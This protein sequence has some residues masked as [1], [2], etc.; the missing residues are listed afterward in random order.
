MEVTGKNNKLSR[1]LQSATLV[2]RHE[3]RSVLLSFGFVFVL[4]AAYYMLRP[5]RDAL[6]SDWTNTEI[7]MLWNLQF[8]LS[9]VVVIAFGAAVSRIR[10]KFLV[11]FVYVFFA[12]SF[13]VLHFGSGLIAD[14]VLVDK[15]FYLWVSLFSLFHVSVF[16]SF[17]ADL[18]NREQAGRLFAIIAVGASAGAHVGPL[19]A[20]VGVRMLGADALVLVASVM[21]LIPVPLV[22]YLQHLKGASLQNQGVQAELENFKIGGSA[23]AGFRDFFSSPY[24][25][26]IAGFILLYTAIGSFAY[27]EQTNLLRSYDLDRRTEILA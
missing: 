14:P 8:F 3:L 12:A 24:L 17:M 2:E 7:S 23:L 20:A 21:L 25:I 9:T 27:F 10:F 16:W 15:G 26:A 4:M 1:L 19:I 22:V 5:V 18:Y 13:L 6:A 11:Q